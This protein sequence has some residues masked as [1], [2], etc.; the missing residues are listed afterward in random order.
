MIRFLAI[1]ACLLAPTVGVAQSDF[2]NPCD[3]ISKSG[4]FIDFDKQLKSTMRSGDPVALSFLIQFP[5]RVNSENGTTS[6]DDARALQSDFARLFPSGARARIVAARNNDLVCNLE[7]VG[8]ADGLVWA[9]ET[10]R[11]YRLV[12]VNQQQTK[13]E[14]SAQKNGK[15]RFICKTKTH[16][17]VVDE[18]AGG[19]LRYR[20]WNSPHN[21]SDAPDM[22]VRNGAENIDGSGQ[23]AASTY[24]FKNSSAV[25]SVG[26]LGCTDGSEPNGATGEL[27]VTVSGK[28]VTNA[29]CF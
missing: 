17:I 18:L 7:G 15:V 22:E 29:W 21:V 12:E 24:T 11:G 26:E 10:E 3:D 2:H 1:A 5:L 9:E 28:R 13:A 23:C 14:T 19:T 6:I 20:S 8:Y 16:K 27:N 4:K 25:Y